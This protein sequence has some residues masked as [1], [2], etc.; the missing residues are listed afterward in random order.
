MKRSMFMLVV[1]WLIYAGLAIAQEQE[2]IDHVT[3]DNVIVLQD[4]TAYQS[5]DPNSTTWTSNDDV[6]VL[7]GDT[8]VNKDENETVDV[9][10]TVVPDE[11]VDENS[12]PQ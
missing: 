7:N 12:D 2:T 11:D 8:I 10:P 3:D 9:T 6:L 1:L 5:N 4:G